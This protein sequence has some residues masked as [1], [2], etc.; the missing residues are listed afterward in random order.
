MTSPTLKFR[1]SKKA[2]KFETISHMIWRLLNKCQIKWEIVSN[3]CGLFRRSGLYIEKATTF[4]KDNPLVDTKIPLGIKLQF[5]IGVGY[6]VGQ[7]Q[8]QGFFKV[9]GDLLS[10]CVLYLVQRY[11]MVNMQ[12]STINLREQYIKVKAAKSQRSFPL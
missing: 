1:F 5:Q 11:V 12:I 6:L 4:S 3:F 10:M 7:I 8:S 2:T 9:F